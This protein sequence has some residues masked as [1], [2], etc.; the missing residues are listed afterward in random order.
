M[1]IFLALR[2]IRKKRNQEKV[3]ADAE[4]PVSKKKTPRFSRNVHG[5]LERDSE[6]AFG[7]IKSDWKI[8]G[9]T[10]SD[11]SEVVRPGSRPTQV[12][13]PRTAAVVSES[14]DRC[15]GHGGVP[16]SL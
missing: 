4:L 11:K 3:D 1:S 10:V 2:Q 13:C 5:G 9:E 7:Q 8:D 15:G 12:R 14:G 6:R 16:G